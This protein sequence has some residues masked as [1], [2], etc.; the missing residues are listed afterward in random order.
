MFVIS[1][2]FGNE[3]VCV[4]DSGCEESLAKIEVWDVCTGDVYGMCVWDVCMGCVYG[5][6]VW[7]VCMGCVYG[8]CVWD[9]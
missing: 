2:C 5:M 6:C 9:V 4:Y 1:E 3:T 7:D 8:M